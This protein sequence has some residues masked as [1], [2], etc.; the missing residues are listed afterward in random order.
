MIITCSKPLGTHDAG[1]FGFADI[2]KMMPP[3]VLE[4]NAIYNTSALPQSINVLP[5]DQVIHG[6][7]P[8]LVLGAQKILHHP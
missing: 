5:L 2:A 7:S 4:D 8:Q 6:L 3:L 1:V